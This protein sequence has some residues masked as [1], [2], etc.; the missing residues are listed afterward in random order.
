MLTMSRLSLECAIAWASVC[1]WNWAA[2]EVPEAWRPHCN[3]ECMPRAGSRKSG[4]LDVNPAIET[5]KPCP[6]MA[7]ALL[8]GYRMPCSRKE[9]DAAWGQ[10]KE[11]VSRGGGGVGGGG[12]GGRYWRFLPGSLFL[13]TLNI[14]FVYSVLFVSVWVVCSLAESEMP[15]RE[16]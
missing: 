4:D 3:A 13:V 15:W 14:G 6:E 1:S 12:L 11:E 16:Q 8:G 5:Y 10:G 2:W 7:R 9:L